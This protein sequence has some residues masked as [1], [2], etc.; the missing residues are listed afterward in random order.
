MADRRT[1]PATDLEADGDRALAL[2]LLAR[3]PHPPRRPALFSSGTLFGQP[4]IYPE[5]P[6]MV[7]ASGPPPDAPALTR[8]AGAVLDALGAPSGEA[9]R[10][11][12]AEPDPGLPREPALRL[13][14]AVMSRTAAAP[15]VAGFPDRTTARSIEFGRTESPGRV[16][17]PPQGGGPAGT[18]V[19]NERYRAEHPALLAPSIAHD[20][21]WAPNTGGHA[22]EAL[23]H[24]LAAIVHLQLVARAPWLA[25][26]GTE[27]CRRQ[28]SLAITLCNSR[29]PGQAR[30]TL[31]APQG[32]GTIP[33]GDP[34]MQ[35]R[36]FWSVPFA[37]VDDAPATE[38]AVQ[39]LE[40]LV[41][42][43]V[44]SSH[45]EAPE[46]AFSEEYGRWFG[47]RLGW[48]WLAPVERLRAVVALGLVDEDDI[49]EE[50]GAV[51]Y[52]NRDAAIA[53]LGLE[54]ALSLWSN[55]G[56]GRPR[57]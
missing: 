51:G 46:V 9:R 40:S 34:A 54:A 27:L 39:V 32:P 10:W 1:G 31:V 3:P 26:L 23:L 6:A 2:R 19:V 42:A 41:E 50:A 28:N 25:H 8:E 35:T 44:G 13:A 18:R 16:V 49:F 21:L 5:G 55:N 30:S 38:V 22:A 12:E 43:P 15:A 17:G 20:L 37:P 56:I 33:G 7:P 11:L 36:D 4:G 48:H 57:G 47:A 14:F 52:A 24:A 53:G 29:Q 45:G